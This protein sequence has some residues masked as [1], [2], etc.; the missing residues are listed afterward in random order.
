MM[1]L[2]DFLFGGGKK[3]T[4]VEIVPDHIWMTT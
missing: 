3:R 4:N 2:F 1:G